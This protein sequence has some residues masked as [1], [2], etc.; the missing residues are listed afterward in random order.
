MGIVGDEAEL[1][2]FLED[3]RGIGGC[4]VVSANDAHGFTNE[5]IEEWTVAHD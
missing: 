3:E 5:A 1:G 2:D 4:N